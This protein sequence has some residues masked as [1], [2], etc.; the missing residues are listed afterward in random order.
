MTEVSTLML[1]SGYGVVDN[2]GPSG[3][4]PR[5]VAIGLAESLAA[6]GV[7]H[8]GARC[9]IIL[10]GETGFGLGSMLF[11][12]D[13]VLRVTVP[14]EPCSHGA[15]L[16]GVRMPRFREIERYLAIVVRGGNLG[17]GIAASTQLGV[18]PEAPGEFRTRCAWAL[19]YIP[20]GKVVGA[21]DFLVA[22]GAGPAYARTLPRWMASAKA[23]GKPVH[24]VLAAGFTAPSWCT[25]ALV[26]LAQEGAG[27]P[28]DA[29]FDLTQ[30]LWF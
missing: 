8:Q 23:M 17:T 25:E 30:E 14:C 22:I 9:N 12:G 13:V 18:Y 7:S 16:A 6:H 29:C 15:Q 21:Q 2:V 4:T 26:L 28:R 20:A 19:D 27:S 24:R 11:L 1:R 5:Q 10:E 3:K